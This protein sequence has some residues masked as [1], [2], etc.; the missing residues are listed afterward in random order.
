MKSHNRYLF[1]LLFFLVTIPA[2]MIFFKTIE[3]KKLASLYAATLFV[4]CSL[5]VFWGE[6]RVR[7]FKSYSLWLATL[8]FLIFSA[9]M[10]T[11]R[12]INYDRDF[13]EINFGPFSGPDFH[14]YSTYGF[15]F[16]LVAVVIDY[17]LTKRKITG[18]TSK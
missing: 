14:K 9:P 13:T 10:L 6:F 15:L 16:L 4:C 2:V 3:P 1:Y 8:F 12:L 5:L 7:S 18:L 17:F 11:L